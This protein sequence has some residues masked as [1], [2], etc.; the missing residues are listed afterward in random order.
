M[1]VQAALVFLVRTLRTWLL[2][3]SALARHS[4]LKPKG[5]PATRGLRDRGSVCGLTHSWMAW[6]ARSWCWPSGLEGSR[7]LWA[8]MCSMASPSPSCLRASFLAFPMR[9]DPAVA[10]A[11][12]WV[13]CGNHVRVTSLLARQRKPNKMGQRLQTTMPRAGSLAIASTTTTVQ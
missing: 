1:Q 6:L 12:V 2:V 9:S 3:P 8:L 7:W 4:Q 10:H 11:T 5:W 13:A